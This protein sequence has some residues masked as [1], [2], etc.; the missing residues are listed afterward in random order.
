MAEEPT[1]GVSEVGRVRGRARQADE[2]VTVADVLA[3][4]TGAR[5]PAWTE[6]LT[7]E[8]WLCHFARQETS[9]DEQL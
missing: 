6:E 4:G 9:N 2:V 3:G 8:N 1:G 5:P 7:Y